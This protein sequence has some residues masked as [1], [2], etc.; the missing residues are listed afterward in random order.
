MGIRYY[1]YPVS[2]QE[3]DEARR[4]PCPFHGADP[5]ADAWGPVDERPVMLYLDK[6]WP[7]L[8]RAFRLDEPEQRPAAELV[9]GRVTFTDDGWDP[10]ERVLDPEE[11]AA[12]AADLATLGDGDIAQLVNEVAPEHRDYLR[13]HLE[14][15]RSF[16]AEMS[17]AGHGLVYLIG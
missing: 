4:R 12:I 9:R 13:F 7:F 5:M 14:Q 1:A 2:S 16:T 8:Q 6:C 10:Y 3:I 15:A 11:V 17:E